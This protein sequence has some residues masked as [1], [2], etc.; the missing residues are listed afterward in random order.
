MRTRLKRDAD[1]ERRIIEE[2]VVD[3]YGPDERAMSWYC[4][5]EDQLRFPFPASCISKR[6]VSPLR[7]KDRVEL[8]GM[9]GEN[10]CAHDMLVM[11]RWEKYR[12]AVPLAQLEPVDG[13]DP[14]TAR[15]IADWHYWV[16]MGYEF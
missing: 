5:L 12:F 10:N 8:I 4:Y 16:R 3:S 14:Q 11:I 9:P 13:T 7:V 6:S 15:A 2:I 1:R